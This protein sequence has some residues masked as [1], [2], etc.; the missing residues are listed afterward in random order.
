MRFLPLILRTAACVVVVT[1]GFAQQRLP[2]QSN[3]VPL[4]YI[5]CN[6]NGVLDRTDIA[7]G[8]SQDCDG[9]QVPD[10]C[11]LGGRVLLAESFENGQPANWIFTSQWHV[12]GD[13]PRPSDCSGSMY[14]YFGNDNS[15]TFGGPG[16]SGEMHVPPI[17]LPIG[18]S[19]ILLSYCSAYEGEGED[20][21]DAADVWVNG[22]LLD[23]VSPQ[24]QLDWE[25]RYIDLTP[26][27]GQTVDIF[28][29]FNAMD[30]LANG[31]LGWQVDNVRVIALDGSGAAFDCNANGVLDVCEPDCNA[32]GVPDECDIADELEDDCQGNGIPDA[33]EIA[34]GAAPDCN[35]N[36]VPDSCDLRDA[37]HEALVNL[38]TSHVT[39][40]SF[41]PDTFEFTGGESGG[42]IADGGMNMLNCGNQLHTNLASFIPYTGGSIV[43]GGASQF[44]PSGR[45]FTVK[46][47]GI[48]M[49]AADNC[50]IDTF[51]IDGMNGTGALPATVDALELSIQVNGIP[52]SGYVKRVHGGLQPSVNQLLIVP[53]NG[54]GIT[55]TFAP[56]DPESSF[57]QL[58]GL[59]A[60]ERI[61]YALVSRFDGLGLPLRPVD[62][63][64]IAIE[65]I[66]AFPVVSS[67]DNGNGIPDECE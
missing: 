23:H 28:F 60:T 31:F 55:H 4:P 27:A 7:S 66:K 10:E 49:L 47:P 8:L 56:T 46:Y 40:T 48:F 36:L 42:C 22:Q 43:Q 57:Q 37:M 11:E 33:C 34:S 24:A 21:Y 52:Y 35:G 6:G 44:G 50:E 67:D 20:P 63:R 38:A 3:R 53:G 59:A 64:E 32:N 26:F 25:E 41:F 39:M 1:Q 62:A 29:A 16:I 5:D 30:G 13:C 18:V 9:N 17:S 58:D 45:Y 15:C 14:A 51:R 19:S 2:G 12:T 65:M 54:A 61:F